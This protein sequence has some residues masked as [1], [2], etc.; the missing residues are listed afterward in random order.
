MRSSSRCSK[1]ML[2]GGQQPVIRRYVCLVGTFLL[3][4]NIA[5]PLTVLFIVLYKQNSTMLSFSIMVQASMLEFWEQ[6]LNLWSSVPSM[7]VKDLLQ[8]V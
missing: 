1:S 4:R 8:L 2:R 6:C 7:F 3:D 5:L